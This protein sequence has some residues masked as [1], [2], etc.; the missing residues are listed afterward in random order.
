MTSCFGAFN[1]IKES[2]FK[3]CDKDD[4]DMIYLL[5]SAYPKLVLMEDEFGLLGI[6]TATVFGRHDTVSFFL[7]KGVDCNL[8]SAKTGLSLL[9]L[10]ILHKYDKIM[11][12]L[13]K[14]PK[15][16][17]FIKT[18]YKTRRIGFLNAFTHQNITELYNQ[19]KIRESIEQV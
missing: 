13:L 4:K 3:A 1:A 6:E 5:V 17:V 12:L 7:Q 19:F 9:D 18:T 10:A 8:V 2:F 15:I 11:L 14:Q 16:D